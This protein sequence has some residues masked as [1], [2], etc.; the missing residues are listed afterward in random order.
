VEFRTV[1]YLAVRRLLHTVTH[2]RDTLGR[3]RV[4]PQESR[5]A[6]LIKARAL[7]QLVEKRGHGARIET[8]IAEYLHTD[9]VRFAFVLT[10]VIELFLDRTSL[11]RLHGC[12]GQ[13]RI[14]ARSEQRERHRGEGL[15]RILLLL[16]DHARDVPLGD[17]ADFVA[18]YARQ[19]GFAAGRHDETAVDADNAGRQR[20]RIDAGILHDEESELLR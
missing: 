6:A 16:R 10:G 11:C 3:Q 13:L 5:G 9:T 17:V 14:G 4:G 7:D 1:G 19:L 8:G 20:K 15:P 12:A 18:D 2:I